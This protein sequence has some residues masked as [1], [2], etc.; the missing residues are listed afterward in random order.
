[1]PNYYKLIFTFIFKLIFKFKFKPKYMPGNRFVGPRKKSV[2]YAEIIMGLCE[3][4]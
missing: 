1:M 2:D 3:I 4:C